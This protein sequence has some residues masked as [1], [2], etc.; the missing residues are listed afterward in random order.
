VSAT[1]PFTH[2]RLTEVDDVGPKLGIGEAQE[3]RLAGAAL[4]ATDTGVTLNRFKPGMRQAIGH[5]HDNAEEIFVV[6]AGS[7]RVKLDDAIVELAPMDAV[8]VAPPVMRSFEAG[9]EGLEVL[10]FG[11]HHAGDGEVQVGW[12]AD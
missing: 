8:R 9:P 5:R 7:G 12:W 3:M 6:L 2:T 11:P 1:S 4:D 10:V